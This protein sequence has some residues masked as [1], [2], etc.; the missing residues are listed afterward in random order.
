MQYL[1]LNHYDIPLYAQMLEHVVE[2]KILR[3]KQLG[4]VSL[5]IPEIRKKHKR[6]RISKGICTAVG[7]AAT[8]LLFTPAAPAAVIAL[9]STAA[10][11]GVTTAVCDYFKS[12]SQTKELQMVLELSREAEKIYVLCKREFTSLGLFIFFKISKYL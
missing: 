5:L 12:K 9:G 3:E 6:L 1:S 10:A 4:L 11:G 2:L 8:S 7:L